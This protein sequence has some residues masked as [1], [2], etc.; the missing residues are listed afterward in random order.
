MLWMW[1][2]DTIERWYDIHAAPWISCIALM[3]IFYRA[4]KHFKSAITDQNYTS[5]IIYALLILTW[6]GGG[7]W[8]F[9]NVKIKRK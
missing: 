7:I 6:I 9:Q 4:I 3:L 1:L 2:R 5:I 8:F